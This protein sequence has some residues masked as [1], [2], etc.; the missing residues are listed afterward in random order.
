MKAAYEANGVPYEQH[1]LK[2]YGHDAT[3]APVTLPNGTNQSQW[4]S[5]FQFVT[6]VLGLPI[7]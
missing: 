5:M 1:I 7:V 2:G 3:S 6:K 4:D